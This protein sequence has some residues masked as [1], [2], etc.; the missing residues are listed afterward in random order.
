MNTS[1]GSRHF[2]KSV[3]KSDMSDTLD[4]LNILNTSDTLDICSVRSNEEVSSHYAALC[5]SYLHHDRLLYSTLQPNPRNYWLVKRT[6]HNKWNWWEC[7]TCLKM[8]WSSKIYYHLRCLQEH[9]SDVSKMS[10]MSRCQGCFTCLIHW[11]SE[12]SGTV[13]NVWK[14]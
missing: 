10:K 1:D 12:V 3:Y 8:V 9:V 4:T 14:R 13:W 2:R 11:L 7:L 5:S 6:S